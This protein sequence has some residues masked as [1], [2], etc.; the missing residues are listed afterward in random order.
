[1]L[2]SEEQIPFRRFTALY[3][4]ALSMI[5]IL[6]I[7]GQVVVQRLLTTIESD[8]GLVNVAG[9]QRMLSQRIARLALEMERL[10]ET[11]AVPSDKLTQKRTALI[12]S[13]ELWTESHQSLRTDA[14]R[15]ANSQD[16]A[17]RFAILEPHY[18][19]IQEGASSF[20]AQE[21]SASQRSRATPNSIASEVIE[22]SEQF[23]REMDQI[24]KLFEI[25]AT[26]RV[27]NLE[28]IERALLITTLIVLLLEGCFIFSPAIRS[29]RR[30]METNAKNQDRLRVAR[31]EA[32]KA[33]QHKTHF[34]ARV[35]H[36]LR[37]PLHAILGMLHITESRIKSVKTKTY[38]QHATDATRYLNELVDDLLDISTMEKNQTVS[39]QPRVFDPRIVIVRTA[40]LMRP[41]AESKGLSLQCFVNKN[42][43]GSFC[44]DPSRVKQLL[45]N[46][47]QN[48]IRYT[49]S[50]GITC[51]LESVESTNLCLPSGFREISF[52][53]NGES[54]PTV[55]EPKSGLVLR[56]CDTG[57]G[58]APE[59][60]QRIFQAFERVSHKASID[61]LM[62]D[63]RDEDQ[64]LGLGLS[65]VIS[66]LQAMSGRLWL[67]SGVAAG[68]EIVVHIPEHAVESSMNEHST[69]TPPR[70]STTKIDSLQHGQAFTGKDST[71]A[72]PAEL[73]GNKLG[74]TALV[75]DDSD[76][77][78]LLM[79]QYLSRLG[80]RTK[81]CSKIRS[82]Q[83]AL[84]RVRFQWLFLDWRLPSGGGERLLEWLANHELMGDTNQLKIVV[85]TADV[86]A[87]PE[88]RSR[89]PQVLSVLY[90]P[91]E[92]EALRQHLS[93][94]R[95]E[96]TPP[97]EDHFAELRQQ[98]QRLCWQ[99]L[100]RQHP[101]MWSAIE[102]RSFERLRFLSHR[103]YGSFSN[104]GL[105]AFADVFRE[106]ETGA[107]KHD[108]LR[109]QQLLDRVREE[110]IKLRQ[111]LI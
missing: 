72:N 84:E 78:R 93:T 43:S 62:K 67:K 37:T 94:F 5:A 34:L 16:L 44:Q 105:Q 31:D 41:V 25:D 98:L 92:F 48:A 7:T 51:R 110:S 26:K 35:S 88:I 55:S 91:L 107:S 95:T 74:K 87:G 45:L 100:E 10:L 42:V 39:L 71:S 83:R 24:V 73:T 14:I 8:A 79:K 106:L 53:W 75:L 104:A 46:L 22:H 56:V 52:E 12:E 109:C 96:P 57:V 60:H 11:D 36:E 32:E 108:A 50:G 103:L 61:N 29:L 76:V 6:S 49:H 82:A 63:P 15:A 97:V 47:F 2:G 64:G 54:I 81:T 101:E 33:N 3:I 80:F 68:T 1:M 17:D 13:V 20:T 69:T 38:L 102:S 89:Y 59:N 70:N 21:I 23:L 30:L 86:H 40:D 66:I 19:A 58:I 90:K 27:A 9:R 111:S 77:N 85:V 99:D 4:I 18:Q 28:R 65:V